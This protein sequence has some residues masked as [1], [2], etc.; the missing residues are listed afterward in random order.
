MNEFTALLSQ[1]AQEMKGSF[2]TAHEIAQQPELWAKVLDLLER[3]QSEV[4]SFMDAAGMTGTR[5][6]V[7]L[8]AGAG[9]SAFVGASIASTLRERLGR[10]VE[11]VPTTDLVTHPRSP[12][13]AHHSYVVVHFA[14]S[15]DSPESVAAWRLVSAQ[16]PDASHLVITC[17]PDGALHKEAARRPGA[18]S[19][20]L[21]VESNDQ[22]LAMTSSFTSMA[23]CGIGMGFMV[24]P[25]RLRERMRPVVCGTRRII[26][27]YSNLLADLGERSYSKACYLGSHALAGAMQE[28]ALKM[29]EMT[30][31]AVTTT[32]NSFLGIRHGPRVF[33]DES[34]L[35]VAC[36]SSQ[37]KVRCYELDLLRD[38]RARGQ[39]A[40]IL[41]LSVRDDP[42]IRALADHHILIAP[43]GDAIPDE[44]RVLTDIV[45]CQLLAFFAARARGLMPDCPSPDG[46]IS[47][48]VQGVRIYE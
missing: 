20:L 38:L 19:L 25:G 13:C 15:G 29:L 46:V 28:G 6:S 30:A 27:N 5:S 34:C 12:F 9:S 22:S 32:S 1:S 42:E 17:N 45:A 48:V 33:I 40:G 47:R 3:R 8:L 31:G 21:P 36:L 7:A 35:V 26:E 41:A 10:N 37:E 43:D 24:D 39:G 11:A 23:L 16:R 4:R 2:H 14:R 44:L 18:L